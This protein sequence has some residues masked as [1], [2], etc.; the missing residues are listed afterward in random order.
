MDLI[1]DRARLQDRRRQVHAGGQFRVAVP[2]HLGAIQQDV[3]LPGRQARDLQAILVEI[4]QDGRPLE[5]ALGVCREEGQGLIEPLELDAPGV[6]CEF[7]DRAVV[8]VG[9]LAR[10]SVDFRGGDQRREAEAFED[11]AGHDCLAGR[12]GVNDVAAADAVGGT[13]AAGLLDHRQEGME[14]V[15]EGRTAGGRDFFHARG[16]FLQGLV[17]APQCRPEFA[18]LDRAGRDPGHADA[19]RLG[20]LG[21]ALEP[22]HVGLERLR[23]EGGVVAV[24]HAEVDGH[25]RGLEAEHVA[26]ESR[27][28]ARRAV[29]ADADV[30]EFQLQAGKAAD[31]PHLQVVAIEVLLGD[32][33]AHHGDHVAVLEEEI[34]CTGRAEEARHARQPTNTPETRGADHVSS[35]LA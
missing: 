35:F 15:G 22:V 20:L 25:G 30:V 34:F 12:P 4:L 26:R 21:D 24:V 9:D 17:I 11:R 16:I 29:A 33:V 14:L 19:R 23:V 3:V 7:V 31:D 32:A 6:D 8:G 1:G 28:A 5:N 13:G 27:I 18:L 10:R 2:G